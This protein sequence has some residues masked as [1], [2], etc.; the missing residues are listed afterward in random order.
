MD[1]TDVIDRAAFFAKRPSGFPKY[2]EVPVPELGGTVWVKKLNAGEQDALEKQHTATENAD[3]RARVVAFCTIDRQGARLFA[4]E[5]VAEL[6]LFG[7]EVLD[8]IVKAAAR[9]NRW[10]E[11]AQ[12]AIAKNSNGQAG[13]SS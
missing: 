4:D 11:M 8:P 12:E 13:V 2:E 10:S 9:L 3:F 1:G 7:A 5:D 6:S